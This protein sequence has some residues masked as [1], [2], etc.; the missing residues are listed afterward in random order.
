MKIKKFNDKSIAIYHGLGGSPID[1]RVEYL[2][3]IGYNN[4]L[5]PHID[6]ENEW[7]KDRCRSLFYDQIDKIKDVDVIIGNSLGGYLAFELAGS[8]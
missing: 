2:K 8:I 4:I 6:Y 3:N 5:Y 1:D 7:S